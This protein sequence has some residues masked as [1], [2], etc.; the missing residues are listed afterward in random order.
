MI[1]T[2]LYKLS[3]GSIEEIE[4]H[5]TYLERYFKNRREQ[6]A[7]V[8]LT[9]NFGVDHDITSMIHMV[10]RTKDIK[11]YKGCIVELRMNYVISNTDA[12]WLFPQLFKTSGLIELPPNLNLEQM[13]AQ[14]RDIKE[15]DIHAFSKKSDNM[16]E[17]ELSPLNN[18]IGIYV[19][20]DASNDW[21][22]V[23]NTYVL[24][25]N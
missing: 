4:P 24:G 23:S 2:S 25:Y 13:K 14:I 12:M 5:V 21:G 22:T 3:H 16:E 17:Y 15:F 11:I 7:Q 20:N 8:T 19:H 18:S 10:F 1:N 9:P 6:V